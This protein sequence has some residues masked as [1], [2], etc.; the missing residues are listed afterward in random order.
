MTW[1]RRFN[2][3]RYPG[4]SEP[5]RWTDRDREIKAAVGWLCCDLA[6]VSAGFG[7]GVYGRQAWP[8]LRLDLGAR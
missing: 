7:C 2:P 3:R 4:Y 1:R 8:R 6:G 5:R